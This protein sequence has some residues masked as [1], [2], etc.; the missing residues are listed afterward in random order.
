MCGIA[1]FN[2]KDRSLVRNMA[3]VLV[4]RGPDHEG[5]YCDEF[6]SLGH[7]RL[8]ILDLSERGIQPMSNEDGTVIIVFNGE[9]FNFSQLKEQ[10]IKNGHVFRSQ[11]DTEVLVHLYEDYGFDMLHCINGQFSFCIYDK[12]KKKLF[13]ARD[14]LGI[15]P[16]YYYSKNGKF[17]FSSELKALLKAGIRKDINKDAVVFYFRFGYIAAPLCIVENVSKLEAAHYLVYDVVKGGIVRYE[18]YWDVVQ[19]E[20]PADVDEAVNTIRG[21]IDEAV[22]IRLMSDVPLGAFLSGGIDSSF[23]V[24]SVVKNRSHLKTFSIKFD[25]SNFDESRYA[26]LVSEY[27][28]TEHYEI[29][30]TS[31]DVR[32]IIPILAYHFDEPFGDPSAIPTYLVSKVARKHVTVCLS[33]DGGDELLGGYNRYRYFVILRTLNRLPKIAREWLSALLGLLLKVYPRFELE[34]VRELLKLGRMDDIHL[35]EA[36]VEKINRDDLRRLLKM[37]INFSD[38]TMRV[39]TKEGLRAIQHYDLIHY[40]EG[41]ILTKVDRAAMA[42]N[43][44]TRP[45]FLDHHLTELCFNLKDNFKIRRWSG[46]WILKKA[47]EGILPKEILTRRKMGFGVP[48]RHYLKAD[49]RDIVERYVFNYDKHDLFNRDFLKNMEGAGNLRDTRR[50]YWNVILFN[51]WHEK[52]VTSSVEAS[53]TDKRVRSSNP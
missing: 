10:L 13:L 5:S 11:T 27:F 16:L 9:I 12:V 19:A 4:H 15:L 14:R 30:F 49:L 47:S 22:K 45:P 6:V 33:G 1:G 32:D 43:L 2:W 41:D 3:D 24:S 39:A 36:L 20:G 23:I 37:E 18:R 31:K 51:L 17:I 21:K 50:I 53:E 35:Y 28:G 7:R 26:K 40:L 29:E 34:K 48:L 25:Y 46:K 52:W 38:T 8:S 42:M 44:E